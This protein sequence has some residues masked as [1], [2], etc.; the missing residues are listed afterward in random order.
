MAPDIFLSTCL[1]A[2]SERAR[3]GLSILKYLT[4]MAYACS[5]ITVLKSCPILF[6]MLV[7]SPKSRTW[8]EISNAVQHCSLQ[9]WLTMS[10]D[11]INNLIMPIITNFELNK[12][13]LSLDP[14]VTL[15]L[16]AVKCYR[17]EHLPYLHGLGQALGSHQPWTGAI[18]FTKCIY[19]HLNSCTIEAYSGESRW[20]TGMGFCFMGLEVVRLCS[21][22]GPWMSHDWL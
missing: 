7:S 21:A 19:S 1:P 6:C 16:E 17:A 4:T 20:M 8:D 13:K 18:E 10:Y 12:P 15:D 11:H 14:R 3:K 9:N 22:A 2:L 5:V